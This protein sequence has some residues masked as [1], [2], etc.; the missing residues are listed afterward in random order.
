MLPKKI[1]KEKLQSLNCKVKRITD[2][3]KEKIIQR[4]I[5]KYNRDNLVIKTLERKIEGF[6]GSSCVLN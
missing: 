3:E 1:R 2:K 5:R 4:Q 6:H